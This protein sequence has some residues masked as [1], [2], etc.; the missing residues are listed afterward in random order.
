MRATFLCLEF[1]LCRVGSAIL[2]LILLLVILVFVIAEL[3]L[4]FSP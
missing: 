4:R 1:C 2:I 3:K